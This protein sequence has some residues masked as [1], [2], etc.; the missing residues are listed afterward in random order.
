MTNEIYD[1]NEKYPMLE[2]Y[3]IFKSGSYVISLKYGVE[4]MEDLEMYTRLSDE[5]YKKSLENGE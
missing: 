4:T 5:I 2:C 1:L 3:K